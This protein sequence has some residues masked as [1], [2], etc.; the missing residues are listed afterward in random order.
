MQEVGKFYFKINVI[1][2]GL[3]K[4]MSCNINKLA[5]IDSFNFLSSS[6]DSL[7]KNLGEDQV[8]KN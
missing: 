1:A 2:D 3:K 7:M 4:C 6:L 5:F 8:F